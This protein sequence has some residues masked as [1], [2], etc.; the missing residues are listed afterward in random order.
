VTR[1]ARDTAQGGKRGG[2]AQTGRD[3]PAQ[4]GKPSGSTPAAPQPR[5]RRYRQGS[6]APGELPE[7][8]ANLVRAARAIVV[9]DG[10][11]G[12]TFDA[13]A[14]EAGEY[15]AA[16]RYYFGTKRNLIAA[17]VSSLTPQA[18]ADEVAGVAERLP[19]GGER[20]RAQVSGWQTLVEDREAAQALFEVFPLVVRD[21]ELRER[22]AGLYRHYR[23]LD[24]QVFGGESQ[25]DG[26]RL[27]ALAALLVAAIDGLSLQALLAPDEIDVD[28]CF[29]ELSDMLAG[30]L[31]ALRESGESRLP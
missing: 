22:V 11:R 19:V 7:A 17:L 14:A 29:E 13:I 10:L 5:R 3:G 21:G 8:A 31:E 9:S 28:L 30:R 6:Q 25:P 4:T 1:E 23:E 18:T 24:V 12:L 20:V 15:R 27:A 26:G 16:V 2:M